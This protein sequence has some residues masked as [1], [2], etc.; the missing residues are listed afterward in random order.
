MSAQTVNAKLKNRRDTSAN[1]SA[2][3]PIL[4]AGEM[5]IESD[6]GKIKFGDGVTAWNSLNY[7]SGGSG[8]AVVLAYW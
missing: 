4:L 3:N 7:F 6:T 5:G 8:T 1:W 2:A